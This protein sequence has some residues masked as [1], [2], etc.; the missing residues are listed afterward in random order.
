MSLFTNTNVTSKKNR[1]I[2]N[3]SFGGNNFFEYDQAQIE[4]LKTNK[5]KHR[6]DISVSDILPDTNKIDS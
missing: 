6:R 3:I 4:K 1:R 5:P 2:R